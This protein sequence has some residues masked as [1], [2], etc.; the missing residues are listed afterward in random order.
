MCIHVFLCSYVRPIRHHYVK[1]ATDTVPAAIAAGVNVN[2][3]AAYENWMIA[4]VEE[5][6]LSVDDIIKAGIPYFE[7]VFA[8]G[9]L[10]PPGSSVYDTYGPEKVDSLANR[11]VP[12]WARV[13]G[14][15]CPDRACVR[16]CA[17]L[18]LLTVFDLLCVCVFCV[19]VW[20]GRKL[21]L[22]AA[23][24]GI[25]LL[26][27]RATSTPWG[28]APLLPLRASALSGKTVAVVGPNANNTVVGAVYFT[29]C[30]PRS[31]LRVNVWCPCVSLSVLFLSL[32]AP[33]LFPAGPVVQLP[34]HKHSCEQPERV[35][36]IDTQGSSRGLLCHI[37]SR[38]HMDVQSDI[39]IPGSSGSGVGG[40][41]GGAGH[42]SGPC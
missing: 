16:L 36:G 35:S 10:D 7:V 29:P 11:C 39:R 37:H 21:A 20:V 4:A 38:L 27:N 40:R 42:R 3:G 30:L 5:G 24:Q 32:C 34:R 33:L 31:C 22:D 13:C 15:A 6:L 8:T 1:N 14:V 17:P 9:Q 41:C 12:Q 25:V 2:C 19:P 18:A 23:V 28:K 26:A